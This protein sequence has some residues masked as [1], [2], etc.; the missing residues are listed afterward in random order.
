VIIYIDDIPV[1]VELADCDP[2]RQLGLMYRHH[3]PENTGMLFSWPQ[4]SIRSFWMKNTTLPLSIAYISGDGRV[5]NIEDLNPLDLTSI[6]S[7]APA[8]HALEMN[9]G[10]FKKNGVS[11][12]SRIKGL[13]ESKLLRELAEFNF[14]SSDFYYKEIVEE[15][16]DD[17]LK[18]LIDGFHKDTFTN[19]YLWDY[20][21]APDI[22]TEYYGDDELAYFDVSVEIIPTIFKADHPGWNIDANAGFGESSEALVHVS[23]QFSESIEWAP[24][25]VD[26]LRQELFNVI[27]HEIHHLTQEGK[28]FE[29]PNCPIAPPA[30][31]DSY[32]HYFSQACEVPSFLI[33]FRGEAAQS[34]LAIG[35]LID[36]YLNNYIKV[37]KINQDEAEEIK[38]NWLGHE[39]W[40]KEIVQERLI[41]S[42]V[43]ALLIEATELPSQYHQKI[44]AA[45]T[46]SQ[47]WLQD[48]SQEEIDEYSSTSGTVMG[49]DAAEALSLA[50]HQAMEDVGLD[51]DILVRS[52]MTDDKEG[53]T[54][55]PDHPAW[56]NRWLVDAKWY[57]SQER[58]GRN[59]I[60]IEIMTSEED[61][62]I[63]SSLDQAALMRHITQTIR[64]ELV[65]YEQMKKQ[66]A[67]K[68]LDEMEAFK[69]M[70]AD[71][72][73][74]PDRNKPEYWEV[75]EPTGK[76][77]PETKEEIIR[78]EGWKH[79]EYT[80]D[81][82]RSHIEVDAHAHDGAEE[83]LAVYGKED[84]FDML[85][86]GFN[87][88]DPKMPN[89][90]KHYFE[91]LPEDDPALD[92]FRKKLF[93]Q[94]ERMA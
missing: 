84:S 17:I 72:S 75:W 2:T 46:A 79:E 18:S 12:G 85:R 47:F 1:N 68:E 62:D 32:F 78:K 54:L 30:E 59:T 37:G 13:I 34:D 42:Y 7:A 31:G 44:D 93:T 74:I 22:W 60:D 66:A 81:Y 91:M 28:P 86:Y 50:L 73:Q 87:T 39:V 33:G 40:D 45:V 48:N 67:S 94:L 92:K 27:P 20:P 41:R 16:V 65:H 89:A 52:H 53:M 70:L 36:S 23:I 71:P 64:H 76:I 21:I 88:T 55:H 25:L 83:L 38:S 24:E 51:V 57:V 63:V 58:Q 29:R 14:S 90:I 5:L 6:P 77:D 19:T 4:E 9:R 10:W 56:P 69:E 43:R 82:L 35:K 49:T 15:V 11:A 61:D 3:L 26:R 8:A 80:Q